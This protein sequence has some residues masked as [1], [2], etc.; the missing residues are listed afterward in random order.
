VSGPVLVLDQVVKEYGSFRAVDG[1]SLAVEGGEYVV[2]LGSSGSGKTTLLQMIGGFVEPTDGRILMDGRDLRGVPPAK[3]DTAT[4][5]QSYALFPHMTVGENVEFGLRMRGVPREERRARAREALALV[6]LPGM[7]HRLPRSLSGGQQQ[8]VALARAIVTRPR[9]LLLDEPLAALDANL[10]ASMQLELKRLQKELGITFL[11]VTHDQEEAVTLADRIVLLDRGKI[12]DIGS[13]KDLYEAPANRHSARFLGE[14]NV[15][16]GT[17]VARDGEEV[18]VRGPAGTF[19]L[20]ARFRGEPWR[21]SVGQEVAFT[22]RPERVRLGAEVAQ[23][24]NQLTVTVTSVVYKGVLFRIEGA[25][26][27][28]EEPF[29][30]RT[31]QR[32]EGVSPGVSLTVG[33]MT[34]DASAIREWGPEGA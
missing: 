21:P 23:C 8:R 16:R 2:L 6:G 25:V 34:E 7:E 29:I 9:V 11:H 17:V 20:S 30:V 3:R 18:T 10:R 14:N 28:E 32:L 19:R 13:P 4:V 1:V 26:P 33:W 27:G 24:P 12:S 5:F 15:L 22:V 31:S